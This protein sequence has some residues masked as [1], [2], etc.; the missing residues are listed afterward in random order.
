MAAVLF[1][2]DRSALSL[3]PTVLALRLGWSLAA[4]ICIVSLGVTPVIAIRSGDKP[5]VETRKKSILMVCL[6]VV[7]AII[8]R[9][10]RSLLPRMVLRITVRFTFCVAA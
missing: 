9:V 5:C 6:N 1:L 7:V 8:I 3:A 10:T 2:P 4:C